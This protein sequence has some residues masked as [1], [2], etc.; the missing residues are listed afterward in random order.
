MSS[1]VIETWKQAALDLTGDVL[2]YVGQ[3]GVNPASWPDDALGPLR[4]AI[5]KIASL[6]EAVT[7]GVQEPDEEELRDLARKLG[8]AKKEIM[9]M[10][11][12]LVVDQS[13]PTATEAYELSSEAR[14]AIRASREATKAAL[15][16]MGDH[17]PRLSPTPTPGETSHGKP[18]PPPAWAPRGQPAVPAW[19]PQSTPATSVW[20]P[21]PWTCH[22]G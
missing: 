5:G 16:G 3:L 15:R 8:T 4:K 10:S 19:L 2:K 14:E 22:Q 20:P 11:R 1:D 6:V 13:A 9:A 12:G 18:G 7:K 21:P 17:L